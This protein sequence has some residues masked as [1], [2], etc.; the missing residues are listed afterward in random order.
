MTAFECSLGPLSAFTDDLT[1]LS[2]FVSVRHSLPFAHRFVELSTVCI[3]P[4]PVT[5]KCQCRA[6]CIDG[7]YLRGYAPKAG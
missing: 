4:S 1:G 6:R 5:V 2:L 3:A 7:G